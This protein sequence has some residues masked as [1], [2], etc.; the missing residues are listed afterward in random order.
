MGEIDEP[1]T[2]A[3]MAEEAA[4]FFHELDME[5]SQLRGGYKEVK[6]RYEAAMAAYEFAEGETLL[7]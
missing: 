6:A 2:L 7:L 4:E 1:Q 5:T 3:E